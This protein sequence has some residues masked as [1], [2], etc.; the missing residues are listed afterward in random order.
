M[1]LMYLLYQWNL[2]FKDGKSHCYSTYQTT[3]SDVTVATIP[4]GVLVGDVE[5]VVGI[6]TLPSTIGLSSISEPLFPK[7]AKV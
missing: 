2:S 5:V 1:V 4:D 7:T 3:H 6:L